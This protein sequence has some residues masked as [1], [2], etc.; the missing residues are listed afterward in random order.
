M[1]VPNMDENPLHSAGV[2]DVFI[3]PP[4]KQLAVTSATPSTSAPPMRTG[5]PVGVDHSN[6]LAQKVTKRPKRARSSSSEYDS[7]EDVPFLAPPPRS[8]SKRPAR[9][10]IPPSDG[11]DSEDGE[12]LRPEPP[13]TSRLVPV[14]EDAMADP[15]IW[16]PSHRKMNW[17]IELNLQLAKHMEKKLAPRQIAEKMGLPVSKIVNRLKVIRKDLKEKG[18]L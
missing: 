12:I 7:S 2:P 18:L 9:R 13:T 6:V 3:T 1:L 14:T 5:R 17:P 4:R 8:P 15:S 16:A 11:E 10:A